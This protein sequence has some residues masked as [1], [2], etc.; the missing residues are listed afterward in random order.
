MIKFRPKRRFND[1]LVSYERNDYESVL[2]EN[3]EMKQKS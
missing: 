2:Y 1:E 3:N